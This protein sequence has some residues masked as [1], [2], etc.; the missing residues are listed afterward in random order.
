M[1]SSRAVTLEELLLQGLGD[2][3]PARLQSL[4]NLWE[5]AQESHRVRAFQHAKSSRN[6]QIPA[7]GNRP[8]NLFIDQK[9]ICPQCFRQQNGL[10][11][12]PMQ[13]DWKRSCVSFFHRPN[14]KPRGH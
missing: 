9:R 1:A 4:E 3:E 5:I 12:S 2:K 10:P 14:L 13:S 6:R 8:S 7:E 11:F